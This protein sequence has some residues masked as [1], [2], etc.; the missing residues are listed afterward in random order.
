MDKYVGINAISIIINNIKAKFAE[1]QHTHNISD[2]DGLAEKLGVLT[3]LPDIET[4]EDVILRINQMTSTI[5]SLTNTVN[6]LIPAIGEIYI[7]TSNEDPSIRFGGVWEQIKDTFLLASGDIYNTGSVGGEATHILTTEELPAHAHT[8]NRHQLWR[9]ESVPE[10]GVSDGY[11]AS[12][13]T[14]TVYQDNTSSVGGGQPHNNMPPYL[15]VSVW[16]RVA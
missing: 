15:V 13:K 4:S 7:S 5:N 1:R 9:T 2:V 16:K 6:A 12:N 3:T 11:G 14:L 8:F 10:A